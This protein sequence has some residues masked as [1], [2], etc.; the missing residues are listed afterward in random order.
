MPTVSGSALSRWRRLRRP[1][2][3][4]APPAR[5]LVQEDVR[6]RRPPSAGGLD[7]VDRALVERITRPAPTRPGIRAP[8]L[9]N[10]EIS[11]ARLRLR[12]RLRLPAE[13]WLGLGEARRE[14]AGADREPG[15]GPTADAG[16]S[17]SLPDWLEGPAV[18]HADDPF[19]VPGADFGPAVFG[20][21]GVPA[22]V[23]P[24]A[25]DRPLWIRRCG[26]CRAGRIGGGPER[27]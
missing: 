15:Q 23:D 24:A 25:V 21:E 11:R 13:G 18:P 27:G 9:R 2:A 10:P 12:L 20:S 1:A 26:I 4:P 16:V 22:A 7:S 3:A 17:A 6:S 8:S 14:P 19:S 5:A